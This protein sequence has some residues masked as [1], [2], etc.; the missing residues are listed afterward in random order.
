VT[1]PEDVFVN[2][3]EASEHL[4]AVSLASA[5][6]AGLTNMHDVQLEALRTT[7]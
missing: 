3:P 5:M 1:P 2:H 7:L 4:T 6:G